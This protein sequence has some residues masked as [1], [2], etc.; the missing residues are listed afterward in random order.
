MNLGREVAIAMKQS[1][2][3]KKQNRQTWRKETE[4]R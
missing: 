4:G 1:K 2:H 3:V